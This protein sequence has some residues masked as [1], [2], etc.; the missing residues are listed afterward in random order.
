MR[1]VIRASMLIMVLAFSAYAGEMQ[2]GIT[3]EPPQSTINTAPE[4]V[5]TQDSQAPQFLAIE[6]ALD[7]IQGATAL[8]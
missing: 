2:N 5:E 3:S 7:L 1:K 4:S 8:L 6:I